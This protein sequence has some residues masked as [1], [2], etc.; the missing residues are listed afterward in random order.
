MEYK[1][2]GLMDLFEGIWVI[3]EVVREFELKSMGDFTPEF[4]REAVNK[5][6]ALLCS[7]DSVF[8]D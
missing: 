4:G 2:R 1:L 8:G 7:G 3:G 5:G 6:V